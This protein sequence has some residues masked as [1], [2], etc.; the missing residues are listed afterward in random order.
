MLKDNKESQIEEFNSKYN[1]SNIDKSLFVNVELDSSKTADL[2]GKVTTTTKEVFKRFIS[3]PLNV[4]AVI[5]FLG[6]VLLSIIVTYTSMYRNP[7]TSITGGETWLIANLPPRSFGDFTNKNFSYTQMLALRKAGY[8]I[9]WLPGGTGVKPT[10]AS[11]VIKFLRRNI[12]GS[13]YVRWNPW[14]YIDQVK[15]HSSID[16]T[17]SLGRDI[18]TMVWSGALSS[19]IL[20]ISVGLIQ[21][22][23]GVSIGAYIGYH[24][25]GWVDLIMMRLVNVVNLV[26]PIVWLIV[27][28]FILPKSLGFWSLFISLTVIG[29][30]VPVSY[31]RLYVLKIKDAQYLKASKAVGAGKGRIIFNHALPNILGKLSVLFVRRIPII[32]LIQTTLSFMGLSPNPGAITLGSIINDSKNYIS[33]WWYIMLPVGILTL[34]TLSLQIISNGLHDAFDPKS[35]RVRA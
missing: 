24:A 12:D 27:L 23:I 30:L 1:L 16:G 31:T 8:W 3:N 15:H 5:V 28:T 13:F 7:G 17:D 10:N 21:M 6:I 20:A 14:I 35:V 33:M 2:S 32:I 29:F 25:G 19:L 22:V 9:P 26:P 4:I 34:I 11:W 18:W